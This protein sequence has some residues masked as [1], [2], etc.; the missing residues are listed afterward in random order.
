MRHFSVLFTPPLEILRLFTIFGEPGGEYRQDTCYK[1]TKKSVDSSLYFG[2]DRIFDMLRTAVNITGDASCAVIMENLMKP[3]K[4]PEKAGDS[5]PGIIPRV[6][7]EES[8]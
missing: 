1:V 3:G 6:E 2:V 5:K 7:L 8:E 4:Q